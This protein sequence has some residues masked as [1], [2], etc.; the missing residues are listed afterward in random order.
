MSYYKYKP[1]EVD[2]TVIDWS[3]LTKNLSDGL[4][5]EKERRESA[6]MELETKHAEQLQKVQD[7]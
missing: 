3:V 6:K 1:R 5:A 7:F 4:I 2:R